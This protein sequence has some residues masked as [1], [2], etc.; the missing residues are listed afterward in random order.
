MPRPAASLPPAAQE[1][2]PYVGW[3]ADVAVDGPRDRWTV[4]R[5]SPPGGATLSLRWSG[6]VALRSRARLVQPPAITFT[7]PITVGGVTA[8]AGAL[9]LLAVFF[10]AAGAHDLFG[11]DMA[12]FTDRSV[13]AEP[14]LGEWTRALADAV[15]RAEV[16]EERRAAAE[17]ALLE[18]V[19]ARRARPGLASR[20][21]ALVRARSGAGAVAELPEALGVSERTLR[22]YFV[23][24]VGVPLK[25]YARWVRFSRAHE[26]LQGPGNR[27]GVEAAYRFGYA[28][29]AHLIR[30]FRHFAGEP[31]SQWVAAERLYDPAFVACGGRPQT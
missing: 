12:R 11:L 16:P 20:A 19:S 29:Q 28:D 3:Y 8:C 2:C 26:Y 21:A 24:E 9:R 4:Q 23:R 18:L 25:V 31:P 7:G 13:A 6:A 22:R 15:G 5:V 14:L 17:A 30:E 27:S 10:T 1:L